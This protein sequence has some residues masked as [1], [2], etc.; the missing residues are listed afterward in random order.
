MIIQVDENIA[1]EVYFDIGD[2]EEGYEDDI[3]FAVHESGPKE[4][5]IFAADTTS[6]L[7]TPAQAEQ[8]AT[9]L[10]QAARESRSM[11]R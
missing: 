5:R 8:L 6:F 11:P 9:A 3:R 4:V 1:I 7:L 2:R 10:V